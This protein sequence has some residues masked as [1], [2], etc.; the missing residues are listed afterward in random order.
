MGHRDSTVWTG[1]NRANVGEA[2][3]QIEMGQWGRC[4]NE[5]I[6]NNSSTRRRRPVPDW[7][8]KSGVSVESQAKK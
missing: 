5:V 8:K 4:R 6:S 1:T 3:A 2:E 7:E